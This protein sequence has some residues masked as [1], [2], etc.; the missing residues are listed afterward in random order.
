[1]GIALGLV[2]AA[3]IAKVV[4]GVLVIRRVT[5]QPVGTAWRL[6]TALIPRAEISLIIAQFGIAIGGPPELLALAMAVMIGTAV[7]PAPL[8]R[9]ARSSA[10]RRSTP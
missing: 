8:A 1:L 6:S 4:P 2:G 5:H 7:L 9:A 3:V 10:A